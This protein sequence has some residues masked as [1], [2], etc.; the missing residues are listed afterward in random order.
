MLLRREERSGLLQT[1]VRC[2]FGDRES[3]ERPGKYG[4]YEEWNMGP[5][6]NCLLGSHGS[7]YY[8]MVL[9]RIINEPFRLVHE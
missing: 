5:G 6:D 1:G 8:V 9:L 2:Q 7:V 4:R 3:M